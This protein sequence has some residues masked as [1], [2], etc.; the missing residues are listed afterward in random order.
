VNCWNLRRVQDRCSL[1]NTSH[2]HWKQHC[3]L[4]ITNI[5]VLLVL[6]L[7]RIIDTFP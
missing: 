4:I 5:L 1:V 7:W 3:T 6:R 2:H